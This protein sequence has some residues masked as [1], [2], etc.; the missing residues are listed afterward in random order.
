MCFA[1]DIDPFTKSSCF[2]TGRPGCMNSWN[3]SA[4]VSIAINMIRDPLETLLR[5]IV[6]PS[7]QQ[8]VWLDLGPWTVNADIDRD[9]V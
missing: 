4:P 8:R 9:V 1:I 6:R 2:G 5:Q 7:A 3:R